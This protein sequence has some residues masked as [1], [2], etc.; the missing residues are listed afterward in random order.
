MA[1]FGGNGYSTLTNSNRRLSVMRKFSVFAVASLLVVGSATFAG[2]KARDAK[3]K[4]YTL[5][6]EGAI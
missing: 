6:L 3:P 4:T 2:P 1:F 5:V